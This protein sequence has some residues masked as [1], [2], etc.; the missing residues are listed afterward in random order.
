MVHP[1]D[2][3]RIFANQP[4]KDINTME[5]KLTL[6]QEWDKVFPQSDKAYGLV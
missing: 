5:E 1:M 2:K 3:R 4:I 6:M